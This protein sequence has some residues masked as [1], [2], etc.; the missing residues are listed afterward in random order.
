[1]LTRSLLLVAAAVVLYAQR[2]LSSD[3]LLFLTIGDWGKGGIYGDITSSR[4]LGNDN[5]NKV[6]YTYQAAVARSMVSYLQTLGTKPDFVIAL[7]DNFY[8]NGV[9]STSD[10]MWSTHWQQVYLSSQYLQVPWYPVFGN[11][12]YGYGETGLTAQLQRSKQNIDGG[13]WN[14]PGKNYSKYFNVLLI[15]IKHA[16]MFYNLL[17]ISCLMVE[18]LRISFLSIPPR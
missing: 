3:S 18:A 7:G 16:F 5:N 2:V 4:R 10:A 9:Y 15:F 14:F 12:D 1:M 11:H 8:D 17:I 13:L 6:T